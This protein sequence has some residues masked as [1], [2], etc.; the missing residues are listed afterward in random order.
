MIYFIFPVKVDVITPS[1][2]QPVTTTTNSPITSNTSTMKIQKPRP[3]SPVTSTEKI[4]TEEPRPTR[5]N[6]E[7]S[8]TCPTYKYI[9][10]GDLVTPISA[11]PEKPLIDLVTKYITSKNIPSSQ[12]EFPIE[13]KD[14]SFDLNKSGQGFIYINNI[15]V[16]N[17]NVKLN[18]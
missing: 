7:N 2:S 18:K 5:T 12:T 8:K 1:M 4:T 3:S 14:T 6:Q 16:S 13:K 17:L 15:F 10:N 11:S 9:N